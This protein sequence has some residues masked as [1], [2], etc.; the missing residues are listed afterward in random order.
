MDRHSLIDLDNFRAV[1]PDSYLFILTHIFGA[2]FSDLYIFVLVYFL[3]TVL[4]YFDFL[5]LA[6]LQRVVVANAPVHIAFGVDEEFL[7][8]SLVFKADF[9]CAR[10]AGI[11]RQGIVQFVACIA[12]ISLGPP[13]RPGLVLGQVIDR[14]IILIEHPADDDRPVGVAIDE[15]DQDFV[16]NTRMDDIAQPAGLR[17]PDP[18]AAAFIHFAQTV[19]VKLDFDPAILVDVDLFVS[20][21]DNDCCLKTTRHRS[22]R[23]YWCTKLCFSWNRREMNF[24]GAAAWAA[25]ASVLCGNASVCGNDQIGG[26]EAFDGMLFQSECIAGLQSRVASRAIIADPLGAS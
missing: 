6:D 18:A 7:F 8:T 5:I 22:R 11:E 1:H 26:F 9:I 23:D 10:L 17:N 16:A 25:T 14:Q 24:G 2:I 12:L 20:G 13:H 19:P 15:I 21:A 4:A 3:F